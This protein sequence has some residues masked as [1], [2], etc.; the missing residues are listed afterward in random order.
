MTIPKEVRYVKQN[1]SFETHFVKFLLYIIIS[2]K[3]NDTNGKTTKY[4]SDNYYYY[5]IRRDTFSKISS[6]LERE[7]Q[8]TISNAT[9]T[10][11]RN[12]N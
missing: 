1:Q 12:I 4:R 11:Q 2:V 7:S 9:T 3:H 10:T 8:N 6:K 5:I